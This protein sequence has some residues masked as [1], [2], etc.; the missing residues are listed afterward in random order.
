MQVSF[1]LPLSACCLTVNFLKLAILS[2]SLYLLKSVFTVPGI[3]SSITCWSDAPSLLF[4][5]KVYALS[6]TFSPMFHNLCSCAPSGWSMFF[7]LYPLWQGLSDAPS[8]FVKS[9]LR[10]SA[11]FERAREWTIIPP[12]P[13]GCGVQWLYVESQYPD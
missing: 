8:S 7:Q 9:S 1:L 13:P 10:I 11:F 2:R 12:L 6:T 3:L 4:C 5:Q